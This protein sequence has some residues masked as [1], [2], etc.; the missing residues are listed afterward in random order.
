MSDTSTARALAAP[1]DLALRRALTGG[2]SRWRTAFLFTGPAAVASIAY[3]DP[4]NFATNIQAGAKH[5]YTLLWVVL[6]ANVAAMLFQALSAKLGIVTGR[7]LAETCRDHVPAPIALAMWVV[8]EIAAMATDLAEFL[9]GAIGLTLLFQLP[10]L[11]VVS[12]GIGVMAADAAGALHLTLPA[13]GPLLLGMLVTGALTFVILTLERYGFRPLELV[14]GGLIAVIALCY[15]AEMFIPPVDW[16]AAARAAVTPYIPNA[17]ALTISV[18]IIG[19]TVMP[20]AIY[21]HS[22]LTQRRV[23][24]ANRAEKRKL[25][26]FSNREVVIALTL[27]GLVNMAMVVMAAG[28]F[29]NGHDDVASIE[30]AYYTLTPLLGAGAAAIFL[31]SLM[32]SGISSS[33]VGTMAGQMIMQGFVRFRIPLWLRRL[34]TM[35]PA[36]IVVSLGVNSTDAIIW[37]QIVLSFALPLPLV[38]LILFTRR[39]DVM[40]EFANRPWMQGAAVVG[41]AIILILNVILILQSFGVDIPFLPSGS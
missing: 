6:F 36:F 38:A 5:G 39:K 28:T 35:I 18:G 23:I 29:H 16:A 27:A 25:L 41:T 40:G 8:S 1:I 37:S 26:R 22:G 13:Q 9:G 10:P 14:I 19:A 34:V 20:H 15:I 31:A 11:N 24:P 12:D 21:L 2:T 3:M 17:D 7:N 30:T 33:V 4:G 32:A